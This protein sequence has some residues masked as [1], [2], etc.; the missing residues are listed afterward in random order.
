MVCGVRVDFNEKGCH[1]RDSESIS[2]PDRSGVLRRGRL[3]GAWVPA[4]AGMGRF[5]T[6]MI[7]SVRSG[8]DKVGT[9]QVVPFRVDEWWAP[10]V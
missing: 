6:G 5:F 4:F 10:V 7:E 3:D 1:I 2:A 9:K 8:A